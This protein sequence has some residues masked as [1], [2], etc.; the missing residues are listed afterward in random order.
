MRTV[1][2]FYLQETG[3]TLTFKILG[4]VFVLLG[5][6]PQWH[7]SGQLYKDDQSK[8]NSLAA[9]EQPGVLFSASGQKGDVFGVLSIA[10]L[11]MKK[12]VV[13]V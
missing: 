5:R 3:C 7:S 6:A 11:E 2:I 10:K 8:L 12:T 13:A 4:C 1:N 9:T